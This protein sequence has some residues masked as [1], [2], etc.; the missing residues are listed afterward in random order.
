MGARV[1]LATGMLH[2]QF[3]ELQW[4]MKMLIRQMAL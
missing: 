2:T 3:Q 4:C 1:P